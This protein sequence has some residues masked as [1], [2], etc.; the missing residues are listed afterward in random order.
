MATMNYIIS[1]INLSNYRVAI[2]SLAVFLLG[3]SPEQK[4]TGGVNDQEITN[5]VHFYKETL[6]RVGS[7]PLG[8]NWC[9]TWASDDSQIINM[10]DG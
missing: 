1:R 2:V 7:G 5:G 10:D 8:D 9:V 6:R 4:N 3:C